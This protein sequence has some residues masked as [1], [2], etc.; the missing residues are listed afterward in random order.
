M[1]LVNCKS[2]LGGVH[3]TNQQ[4]TFKAMAEGR[5]FRFDPRLLW[6]RRVNALSFDSSNCFYT[7]VH[8][9]IPSWVCTS[10]R[11][12]GNQCMCVWRA[13]CLMFEILVG[14]TSSQHD[15]IVQ[16]RVNHKFMAHIFP[17]VDMLSRVH[18]VQLLKDRKSTRLNSS[19]PV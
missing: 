1:V 10:M 14:A 13:Q 16:L 17:T 11:T 2:R 19:H 18:T 15:L 8:W 12:D 7:V 4:F 6:A 3:S 9:V 5:S